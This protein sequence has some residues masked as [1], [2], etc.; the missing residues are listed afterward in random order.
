MSGGLPSYPIKIWGKSVLIYKDVIS[1]SVSVCL[2]GQS[3]LRNPLTDLPEIF[4]GELG[5]PTG[6]FLAWF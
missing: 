4:I 2:F 3:K 1:V 6:M 5:R